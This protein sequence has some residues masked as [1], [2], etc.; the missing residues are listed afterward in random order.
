M[1]AINGDYT[2]SEA[3]LEIAG[4]GEG[5]IKTWKFHSEQFSEERE[6]M[7]VCVRESAL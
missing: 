7:C 4:A 5:Y 2:R 3:I 1:V 6:S